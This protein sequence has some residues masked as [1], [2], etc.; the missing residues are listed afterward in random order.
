MDL[1]LYSD[2]ACL[3]NGRD[4]AEAGY[5][6]YVSGVTKRFLQNE[7]GTVPGKETNQRAELYAVTR[8]LTMVEDW[9]QEKDCVVFIRTDSDYS[10]R[11]CTEWV[12][13]WKM[14]GY[15]NHRGHPVANRD[16]IVWIVDTMEE[17]EDRV[18]LSWIPREE[19]V[20]ADK[21]ARLAVTHRRGDRLAYDTL[22]RG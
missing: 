2:G 14:N 9:L 7:I 1:E 20:E 5:G 13:R 6:V 16:L 18:V 3:N 12:E 8:A 22:Y 17:W 10:V 21:L 15:R 19:N 4:G 11:C